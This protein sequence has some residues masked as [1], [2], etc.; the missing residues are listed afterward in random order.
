[1]RASASKLGLLRS[2]AFFARPE[3]PWDDSSDPSGQMGSACHD[4][5]ES[6]QN[7]REPDVT[8]I[9]AARNLNARQTEALTKA[10]PILRTLDVPRMALAEVAFAVDLAAMTG[11]ELG[12]SIGRLYKEHGQ[13]DAEIG[14]TADLVWML[15]EENDRVVVCDLKTGMYGRVSDHRDQLMAQALGA[16]KAYG[17][18]K[19]RLMVIHARPGEEPSYDW[20]DVEDFEVEAW[21]MEMAAIVDKVSESKPT[22]GAHCADY[23]PALAACPVAQRVAELVP[24]DRLTAKLLGPIASPAEASAR[25]AVWPALKEAMTS[26][27]EEL[28]RYAIEHEGIA[29]E[30]GLWKQVDK[31]DRTL[32]PSP[33][34]MAV[35]VEEL[36]ELHAHTALKF[37]L[38]QTAI[39]AAIEAAGLAPVSAAMT[40]IMGRLDKAG[41]IEKTTGKKFDFVKR[42]A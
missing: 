3:L 18:E 23:C 36:G 30:D 17:A 11:R 19:A 35:L 38:T 41:A 4:A 34:A 29:T 7:G 1:M 9:A 42:V 26:F 14:A 21:A 8:A 39:K 27:E 12:R 22:P 40:R 6:L 15:V 33:D 37:T 20:K 31:T 28:R 32:V 13:T 5:K 10:I 16:M 2:C 24:V 25:L